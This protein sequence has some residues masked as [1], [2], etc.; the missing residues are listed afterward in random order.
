LNAD[1]WHLGRG[2]RLSELE[3]REE[4]EREGQRRKEGRQG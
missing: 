2:E 1:I 3:E 4:K